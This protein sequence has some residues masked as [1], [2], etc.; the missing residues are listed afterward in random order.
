MRTRV[1]TSPFLR[2]II[3]AAIVAAFASLALAQA[4][5]V[6]T[7]PPT[8]QTPA[9]SA[10][11][12]AAQVGETPAG[13]M[14]FPV[15]RTMG[16]FAL[17]LTLILIAFLVARKIAPQY[18]NKRTALKNL[19]LIESMSMGEKRSIAIVQVGDKRFLVGNTP[20]QLTL[21]SHLEDSLSLASEAER[22]P[23]AEAAKTADPFRRLY[24]TARNRGIPNPVKDKTFPPDVRAKM[25]Q[26]RQALEG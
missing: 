25:R 4:P 13:G 19:K 2:T 21:L 12:Q 17:V 16:G 18:F 20:H 10:P 3:S 24:E 9:K 11:T 14:D 7:P 5:N 23:L 1:L 26:L 22:T 15:L 6:A 8:E